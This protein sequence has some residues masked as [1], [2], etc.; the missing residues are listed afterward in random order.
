MMGRCMD[1]SH[2]PYSLV[3]QHGHQPAWSCALCPLT[4]L[5]SYLKWIGCGGYGGGGGGGGAAA[6]AA[7]CGD[8]V[9]QRADEKTKK[10]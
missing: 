9:M 10:T 1:T 2:I 4:N 3:E 5:T 6:A 8:A 7:R